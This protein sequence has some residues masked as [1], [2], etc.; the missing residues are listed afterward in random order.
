[1]SSDFLLHGLQ[2]KVFSCSSDSPTRTSLND[3]Q[4]PVAAG[5]LM[6]RLPQFP[7]GWLNPAGI[8]LI[9]G[10]GVRLERDLQ[11]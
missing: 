1:L 5:H 6:D 7:N 8:Q 4:F 3:K 9:V 11:Y 10:T 2:A